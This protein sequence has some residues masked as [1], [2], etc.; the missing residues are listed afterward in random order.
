MAEEMK[1]LSLTGDDIIEAV[2]KILEN[3]NENVNGEKKEP[4]LSDDIADVIV[5]KMN[6]K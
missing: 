5:K 3:S 6:I 4:N 2:K 1:T